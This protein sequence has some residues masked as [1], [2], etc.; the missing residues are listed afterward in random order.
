MEKV[1]L[2]SRKERGSFSPVPCCQTA[3]SKIYE[4]MLCSVP[5]RVGHFKTS[6]LQWVETFTF[7]AE[8]YSSA[9]YSHLL[10]HK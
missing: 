10:L 8:V 1:F 7:S 3:V 6:K 9:V 2:E 5:G 4:Q